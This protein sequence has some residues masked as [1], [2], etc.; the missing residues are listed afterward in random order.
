MRE[1]KVLSLPPEARRQIAIRERLRGLGEVDI[2]K[3]WYESEEPFDL[4]DREDSIRRRWD[5]AKAQFLDRKTYTETMNALVEEFGVSIA[6]ARVDIR[7]MRHTFGPL[8]EVPK[9]A[10]R[11]LA[12]QMALKA[13]G[14]AEEEKDADGMAKA[15]KAY[16]S[17]AGLDKEDTEP[18]DIDKLMKI[19]TYVEVMDP[20]IRD[21]LLNLLAQ[22]G[23]VMDTSILFERVH[24]AKDSEEYTN[25]EE[26]SEQDDH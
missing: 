18:F 20:S 9:I 21:M 19:R 25:F 12:M 7:H 23:G 10:R 15:T 17:A 5:Y 11:Q 1:A 8:D 13:F 3:A 22:S 2:V 14:I 24:A 16:I 26:I 4:N 6:Q